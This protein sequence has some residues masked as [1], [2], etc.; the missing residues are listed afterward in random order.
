MSDLEPTNTPIATK[1]D[2]GKAG[3]EKVEGGAAS[4]ASTATPTSEAAGSKAV[5]EA[6]TAPDEATRTG[7][8][9]AS[10]A[11]TSPTRAPARA[12]GKHPSHKVEAEASLGDN[13]TDV[14]PVNASEA[15]F[16]GDDAE[17]DESAMAYD[18]SD[19]PSRTTE[20]GEVASD[21]SVGPSRTTEATSEAT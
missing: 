18:A 19:A 3:Q 15:T 20:V 8:E 10:A 5:K 7:S 1:Q 14:L 11:S 9:T 21:G 2:G 6:T 13:V 4:G 16:G 12:S 17:V